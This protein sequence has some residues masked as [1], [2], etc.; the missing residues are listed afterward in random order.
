MSKFLTDLVIKEIKDGFWEVQTS[1]DYKSDLLGKV[2]EVPTGF[3][4]DFASIPRIPFIYDVLGDITHEP[5]VIHDYLYFIAITTRKMADD[6]LLEAMKVQR[7][8]L[9]K[10][11]QIWAGVRIGG[12]VAWNQH[13][14]LGHPNSKKVS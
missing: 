13:R 2:I 9:W 6:I 8:P 1:L 10:R 3:K 11:W 7:I 5:A 14:K 12:W 4:T